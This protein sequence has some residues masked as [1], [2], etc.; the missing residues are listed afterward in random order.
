MATP[1]K[2][3]PAGFPRGGRHSYSAGRIATAGAFSSELIPGL[4]VETWYAGTDTGFHERLLLYPT[5]KGL[6]LVR[7]YDGDEWE[8]D[9]DCLQYTLME[10]LKRNLRLQDLWFQERVRQEDLE[11]Q[12]ADTERIA[13]FL[14][15]MR[16]TT[17]GLTLSHSKRA[18]GIRMSGGV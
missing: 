10:E 17:R 12:K 15:A 4:S 2:G 13:K 11:V 7:G 9:V 1:E 18:A 16:L 14:H 8:E 3:A 6:W 5:S